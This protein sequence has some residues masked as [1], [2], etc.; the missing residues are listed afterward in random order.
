MPENNAQ[1]F[2]LEAPPAFAGPDGSAP[3]VGDKY[4]HREKSCV[5]TRITDSHVTL[6]ITTPEE[7]FSKTVTRD[8]FAVLEKRTLENGAVFKPAP[9]SELAD[10][11]ER[12]GSATG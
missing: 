6:V 3:V 12:F 11:S 10:R 5:I 2:R 8:E 4:V 7:A 9:N 1:D